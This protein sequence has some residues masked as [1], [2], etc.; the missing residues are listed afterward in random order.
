MSHL[1]CARLL[2]ASGCATSTALQYRCDSWPDLFGC[3]STT[4]LCTAGYCD[5]CFDKRFSKVAA[6]T[7]LPG[8]IAG[9]VMMPAFFCVI[10]GGSFIFSLCIG[11]VLGVC[12][13]MEAFWNGEVLNRDFNQSKPIKAGSK[14]EA[15]DQD[16]ILKTP[17]CGSAIRA[18]LIE[19]Y[20]PVPSPHHRCH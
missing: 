4:M 8:F 9:L 1:P 14:K 3:R 17:S 16:R 11:M 18:G 10:Y 20:A 6:L 19:I 7:N 2:G 5:R 15:A 12:T 13:A